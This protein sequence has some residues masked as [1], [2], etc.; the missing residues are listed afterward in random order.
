MIEK[1]GAVLT[2][3]FGIFSFGYFKG[4]QNEKNKRNKKTLKVMAKAKRTSERINK[5]PSDNLDDEYNKL[6]NDKQ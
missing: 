6:L 5:I 4:V 3:I 2:I 1:I